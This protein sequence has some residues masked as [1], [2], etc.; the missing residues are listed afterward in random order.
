MMKKDPEEIKEMKGTEKI[1]VLTCYDY[2]FAKALD[3]IVD[4]ILV[5][6]SLGNVVLGFDRTKN[7]TMDDMIRHLC[8][9]RS[10]APNTF[11]VVDLP[12]GSYDNEGDAI[13]NANILVKNGADAVKP[14]GRPD[15]VK[16]L[17]KNGINVMGHLGLLPQ[18]ALKFNV[19][20]KEKKDADEITRQA[21]EINKAGAFSL[22]IESIPSA[23]AEKITKRITIPTIGI[24]AGDKCDGQVLVLYGLL[25]LFPDFKPRFVRQYLNLKEEIKKSAFNYSSD[26]KCGKFPS[27]KEIL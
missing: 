1:S 5:G 6:D 9:V 25:G 24:G 22:I 20:G 23:L 17:V 15:I 26:V 19:V 7:V 16:A 21:K 14:E 13:K 12:F 3:G 10:G 11:I 8:A 4:I 2:S 27:K 18:T